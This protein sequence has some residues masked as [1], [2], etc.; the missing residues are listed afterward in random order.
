MSVKDVDGGAEPGSA[1]RSL[2]ETVPGGGI[3][4]GSLTVV[5]LAWTYWG[6]L[7]MVESV[8]S[9]SSTKGEVEKSNKSPRSCGILEVDMTRRWSDC[10]C[11]F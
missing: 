9:R 3:D 10:A 2:G 4:T 7:N 5:K 1:I 11:E 8:E 6:G